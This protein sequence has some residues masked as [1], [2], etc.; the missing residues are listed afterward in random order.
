MNDQAAGS[1][2]EGAS[3][4][5]LS[6]RH[7]DELLEAASRGGWFAIAARRAGGVERR[8]V[9]SGAGLAI[10]DGRGAFDE[11]I[12][13][14]RA[15]ADPV[16][17]NAAA[18]LVLLSRG[19]VA[20]LNEVH[21]A[22][23]THYLA[24]PFGEAEL[25]QALRFAARYAR[26]LSGGAISRP[27]LSRA[28]GMRWSFGA[29]GLT[30]STA[31]SR[32]YGLGEEPLSLRAAYRLLA[33]A[34]RRAAR[35]ARRRIRAGYASTAFSHLLPDGVRVA[36]HL[37]AG[38][39]EVNGL[40]EPLD[41]ERVL[42]LHRDPLTGLPDGTAARRWLGSQLS[43]ETRPGVLLVGMSRLPTINSL[44]GRG[45][46]DALLQAAAR[47]IE[48]VAREVSPG[49]WIARLAG[50]E[51]MVGLPRA[52]AEQLGDAAERIV[53]AV[54]RR[55][56]VAPDAVALGADI[57]GALARDEDPGV[58]LRRVSAALAEAREASGSA[59]R[60]LD[61]GGAEAAERAQRLAADLREALT[62]GQIE[63]LFQPQVRTGDGGIDG[64]E[65]LARWRHP[66]FG[67][68]GA[69]A[70]F[71]AAER[72]DLVVPLSELV[73]RRALEAAAAWPD[74]L[75]GL[76]LSVNVTAADLARPDFAEHM[77]AAIDAS[78][79]A[80]DRVTAEV[81]EEGLI[82]DLG[83]AAAALAR[84]R[85]G[86][87]R[88]A[89][90]DFGT[91]YSSLA[92]LKALPLDYLKLDRRLSQDIAGSARGRVVVRSVIDMARALGLG[93]IAEGVETEEQL[94]LLAAEG[95]TLYQ[96][97]LCS[98]PVG[99]AELVRLLEDPS[100]SS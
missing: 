40:I 96:G 71:G 26:R 64:V 70:L 46:G 80:R 17:A 16:E 81:T 32:S 77:L 61:G 8:F 15:L 55:V 10:V 86:G 21:A 87:C 24:S 66:L 54:E 57:G 69:E 99:M 95:C 35:A 41:K 1:P 29:N 79:F 48:R 62:G 37:M 93:V 12:G 2:G 5:I 58:L 4:F 36:H 84:L 59:I 23:A 60:L 42:P 45:G 38:E 73:Q 39:G 9:D 20:R 63:I 13:A 19:D 91:G 11:A 30:L 85:Q 65:A 90:D 78:G 47:R 89:V 34:D 94:A 6:F 43:A 98:G 22:G 75:A 68:L 25:L 76:R 83:A 52:D 56:A 72:A 67:E 51:F 33:P 18:L 50:T 27:A 14:V 100:R 3:L 7:R 97:F 53:A 82:E 44:Y 28:E 49:A 88:A 31:L 92:Y 74:A